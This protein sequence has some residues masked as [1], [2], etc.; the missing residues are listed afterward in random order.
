MFF[1]NGEGNARIRWWISFT[2]IALTVKW[3]FLI[4][5][6]LVVLPSRKCGDIGATD[7]AGTKHEWMKPACDPTE[8]RKRGDD[9]YTECTRFEERIRDLVGTDCRTDWDEN[10]GAPVLPWHIRFHIFTAIAAFA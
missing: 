8:D 4:S 3:C 5:T 2:A 10:F 6:S 1:K 9:R 7:M